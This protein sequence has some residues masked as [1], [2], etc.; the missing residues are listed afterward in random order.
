M[1]IC[2]FSFKGIVK[3]S[4]SNEVK[5]DLGSSLHSHKAYQIIL[6]QA[7]LSHRMAVKIKWDRGE[8]SA[9]PSTSWGKNGKLNS[10][11]YTDLPSFFA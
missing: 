2:A 4:V 5:R 10:Q 8:L 9:L 1:L 11:F 3:A 6:L 7:N